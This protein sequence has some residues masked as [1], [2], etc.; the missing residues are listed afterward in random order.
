[1]NPRL[2][3]LI[4][5]GPLVV[6]G[7]AAYFL[8]RIPPSVTRAQLLDAGINAECTKAAIVCEGRFFCARDGGEPKRR[9][10]TLGIQ[11]FLCPS[12]GSLVI[13]PRLPMFNGKDC[14]EPRG[15][16][17][18]AC[19]VIAGVDGGCN[20]PDL[21]PDDTQAPQRAEQD[22]CF[23]RQMDAG[24]CRWLGL[25]DGGPKLMGARNIHPGPVQGPA[26]VMAPCGTFAGEEEAAVPPECE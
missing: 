18:E 15:S 13:V 20:D 14:F 9:V 5:I 2:A 19:E 6:L 23:C 16:F 10:G 12:G 24:A 4:I 3:A 22:R 11:A 25:P 8:G 1:M 7:G 26:C 17:S 21:C